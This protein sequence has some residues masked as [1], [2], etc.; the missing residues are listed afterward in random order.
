MIKVNFICWIRLDTTSL[1]YCGCGSSTWRRLHE[2]PLQL[3]ATP[4]PSIAAFFA[5]VVTA[6]TRCFFRREAWRGRTE[7]TRIH[8]GCGCGCG[9]GG[10]EDAAKAP[11]DSYR[12]TRR[13]GGVQLQSEDATHSPWMASCWPAAV[14]DWSRPHF[15]RAPSPQ[16][17]PPASHRWAL[18]NALLLCVM[19]DVSGGLC[20]AGLATVHFSVVKRPTP[21]KP[22]AMHHDCTRLEN[23]SCF[24]TKRIME[25]KRNGHFP[26]FFS[27]HPFF[28]LVT[29]AMSVIFYVFHDEEA[30][31]GCM[32]LR[33]V[34]SVLFL[35][36]CEC[37]ASQP[38]KSSNALQAARRTTNIRTREKN[39]SSETWGSCCTYGRHRTFGRLHPRVRCTG[40]NSRV[41]YVAR[42]NLG[43]LQ[44]A[45]QRAQF[46]PVQA[47]HVFW[48]YPCI[49]SIGHETRRASGVS[50]PICVLYMYCVFFLRLQTLPNLVGWIEAFLRVRF[51]PI[52]KS[53][54]TTI[55]RRISTFR[56]LNICSIVLEFFLKFKT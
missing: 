24:I 11:L 19:L 51:R 13:C 21:N 42:N 48:K 40:K 36:G 50:V 18:I 25:G 29:I 14:M 56:I 44:P 17:Q 47:S 34:G 52:E 1:P 12:S 49:A 10:G 3:Q 30:G 28:L 45:L 8:H 4:S 26:D 20:S 22:A 9:C 41:L 31:A 7:L 23:R 43:W 38:N 16:P 33:C 54:A 55:Y 5:V 46:L 53:K 39:S 35:I 6:T 15:S 2:R 32:C 37:D 27:I